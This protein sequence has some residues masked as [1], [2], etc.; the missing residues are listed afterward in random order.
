MRRASKARI[1]QDQARPLPLTSGDTCPL[2][3]LAT[4]GICFGHTMGHA[5]GLCREPA[6]RGLAAIGKPQ[7]I[8]CPGDDG[9]AYVPLQGAL[10]PDA[11]VAGNRRRI[12]GRARL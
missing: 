2:R 1:I 11:A 7:R 9:V 12:S 5:S 3:L 6:A 10:L 4:R 8:S